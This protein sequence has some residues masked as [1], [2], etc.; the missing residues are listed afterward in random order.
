MTIHKEGYGSI[1][2]ATLAF[3]AIN[4]LSIWFLSERYPALAG[5]I[6]L[7]SLFCWL[8]V[9]SFFRIPNRKLTVDNLK[10]ICPADGKVVVIEETNDPEYFKD[11]RLQVSIFMS[12]LNVHVNRNVVSGKVLYS[13]Y[14]KGKYLV[15]WDP[16]SSTDNE[17][18]SVVYEVEGKEILVKQIAGAVA[19]RIVNYL[20]PGMVVQ[21]GEEMGFIKFGSRVDVLLPP[22]AK[23]LV[24]QGQIVQGG[25]TVLAEW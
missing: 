10:I 11:N 18:H 25:V 23:V 21:Q 5:I 13:K 24:Q 7:L 6:F 14:H 2:I 4:A 8:F 20:S 16:K 22:N 12:P 1:G 17:R 19:R 15:A 3:G 9:I